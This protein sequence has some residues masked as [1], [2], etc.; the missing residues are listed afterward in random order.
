MAQRAGAGKFGFSAAI[1]S[2]SR[3]M[4]AFS[5]WT[6]DSGGTPAAGGQLVED[7]AERE[8]VGAVSTGPPA[9]LFRRHVAGCAEDEPGSGARGAACR[10]LRR[11]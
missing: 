1:G 11:G 3:S 4:M 8:L 9:R 2:G 7:R 6:R 5:V 10:R